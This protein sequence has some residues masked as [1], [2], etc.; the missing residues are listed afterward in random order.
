MVP[1]WGVIVSATVAASALAFLGFGPVPAP[2]FAAVA[3]DETAAIVFHSDEQ[4]LAMDTA[5]FAE[6]L[7]VTMEE[8]STYVQHRALLGELRRTLEEEAGSTFTDLYLSY[9][10]YRIVVLTRG[11]G[12]LEEQLVADRFGEISPFVVVKHA[13][14]TEELLVKAMEEVGSLAGEAGTNAGLADI[15]TGTVTVWVDTDEAAAELRMALAAAEAQGFLAIP[16]DAVNVVVGSPGD[17][18]SFAG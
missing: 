12:R 16:A 5:R 17:E 6:G 8:A 2:G 1:R 10:P 15:R 3:P 18:D 7:G 9:D 11:D 13:P 4:A 14:Y